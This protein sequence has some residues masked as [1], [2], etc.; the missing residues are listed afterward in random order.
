MSELAE[1]DCD[2]FAASPVYEG[3][4][5]QQRTKTM[6]VRPSLPGPAAT[7]VSLLLLTGLLSGP[8]YAQKL[9]WARQAGGTG[10]QETSG[11]AID[12]AGNVLVIGTFEG[13]ADFEPGSGSLS[14][15][16]IFDVYFAKYNTAGNLVWAKRV[17][18]AGP[19]FGYGISA[20]IEGNVYIAGNFNGT[21]DFDPGPGIKNLISSGGFDA[22][23]AKYNAAGELLWAH[24]MGGTQFDEA[25]CLTADGAGNLVVAGTFSDIADFDPS[26]G[27]ASLHAAGS[28]DVYLAKFKPSG[29]LMWAKQVGGADSERVLSIT[30]GTTQHIYIAGHFRG[31]ADFDPSGA[32]DVLDAV[33]DSDVF[34]ARYDEGGNLMWAKSIGGF[35]YEETRG[36]AVDRF[37]NVYITGRYAETVDFDPGPG[38]SE[39]DNA[40][41]NDAFFAKYNALGDLVWAKNVGGAG[42]DI[43]NGIAV[44]TSGQVYLSGQFMN[45][46]DFDPGAGASELTAAGDIEVFLA[47]YD[48]SGNFI[49]ANSI[50]GTQ[51]EESTVIAVDDQQ[52]VCVAGYFQGTAD[53]DAGPGAHNLVSAGKEDGFVAKYTTTTTATGELLLPHITVYPVPAIHFL[54]IALPGHTGKAGIA[55]YDRTGR[56][57]F[58][59]QG[60]GEKYTINLSN[61]D[62]GIFYLQIRTEQGA[63]ILPVE[64]LR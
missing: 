12:P 55:I 35:F 45:T 17:G 21:A 7:G 1:N 11:M 15:A 26:P 43:G 41:I 10:Y 61:F 25:R 32:T 42:N 36:I 54:H 38:V 60:T 14:N 29:E 49:W 53:F 56:I 64:V 19:D 44:D 50:G 28:N 48:A 5:S 6:N 37:D 20:D 62:N 51:M 27:T 23:L 30:S 33:G 57:M 47:R 63:R 52:N 16:G 3:I 40:G 39:L 34:F 46:V 31:A 2:L 59:Q 13:T 24:P 9:E 58:E 18:G 8:L 4:I 22:F